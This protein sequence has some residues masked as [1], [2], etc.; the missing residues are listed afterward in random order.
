MK[1]LII[2]CFDWY[3]KRTKTIIDYFQKQNMEVIYY[4]SDYEHIKKEYVKKSEQINYI[5]AIQ[6]KK[7]FS[8]KRLLSHYVFSKRVYKILNK[9]VPDYVYILIPPNSMLKYAAKYHKKH[10]GTKLIV[11]IIDMWPESMPINMKIAN[12]IPFIIWKDLRD[13]NLKEA[14]WVFTECDLYQEILKKYISN[15][16]IST[17]YLTK[18]KTVNI[19][20]HYYADSSKIVLVYLG[21]IN[22][23]ID[24][25]L[26]CVLIYR[27]SK[28]RKVVLKI[29]G[30]GEKKS[31]FIKRAQ[32]AKAQV[33]DEGV[34][35]DDVL[36][37]EILSKSDFGINIMKKQV[38]VGLTTK[39]IDYLS[40][41][42]PIINN[43]GGDTEYLIEKYKAGFN[44]IDENVEGVA[45]KILSDFDTRQE[46]RENAYKL[47]H[48]N[49]TENEFRKKLDHYIKYI[50]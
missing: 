26:I 8:I 2:S 17:L 35:F 37:H 29:I 18:P 22:N 16:K 20:S 32:E 38:Y 46:M 33:I 47:Y 12:C 14:D 41:G 13:K 11:D 1:M 4:T 21:S 7:N 50:I 40:T 24:I 44:I 43:I 25:D 49:F 31:E 10:S 34:I 30:K 42:L 3:E 23:I 39:S 6:Y 36:K 15:N 5:H 9:H 19:N 28:E 48:E 45:F 27:L